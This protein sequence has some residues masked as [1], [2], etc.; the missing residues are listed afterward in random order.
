MEKL[1]EFQV[2]HP[3]LIGVVLAVM[4]GYSTWMVYDIGRKIGFVR[5]VRSIDARAA[6]E[7][8]GG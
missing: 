3:V 2:K 5:A 6:S 7:A 1:G 4:T 8:M